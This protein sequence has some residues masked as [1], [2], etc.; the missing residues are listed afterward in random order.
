[1]Y[2][3]LPH[4]FTEGDI[5][6]EY[7]RLSMIYHPDVAGGDSKVFIKIQKEYEAI[8]KGKLQPR[9]K[10]KENRKVSSLKYYEFF[11][12][13]AKAVTVYVDDDAFIEGATVFLMAKS[14]GSKYG[15]REFRVHLPPNSK[16]PMKSTLR[17]G[18]KDL[19]VYAVRRSDKK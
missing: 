17:L 7:R 8:K 9:F 5:K 6:K 13:D 18:S 16:S 3:E 1:M 2:F 14:S 19:D 11:S 10:Q 12:L 15:G 4:Y